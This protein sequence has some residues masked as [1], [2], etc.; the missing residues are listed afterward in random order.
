M[1][2]YTLDLTIDDD[3]LAILRG[4][5]LKITLA[6]P[7]SESAPNV[8][9]VVFDPWAANKVE[10]T[11]EFGIY[12]A[13][14]TAYQN[15]ATITRLSDK[16]T[17]EDAA[18][19]TFDSSTT[20]KGPNTGTEAPGIGQYKVYNEMPN[21]LYP[22]LTFGLEQKASVNG[23]KIDPAPINAALVPA[24]LNATFTPLTTVYVWLQAQYT[25]GTVI[26]SINGDSTAVT[27]GGSVTTQA[28]V[29]DP[30]T[31]RFIAASAD[32]K[33]LAKVPDHVQS[34]KRIGVF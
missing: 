29:Y 31:G 33:A 28:L 11:E 27:F 20:F 34:Q 5:Q 21:T 8:T 1:S 4:S 25:S 23:G 7:V 3:S 32:G 16:F 26:T 17:V 9:W 12:A 22:K 14:E 13:P 18:Y 30:K 10:W 15:G 19:Y 2:D 24:A 6:K